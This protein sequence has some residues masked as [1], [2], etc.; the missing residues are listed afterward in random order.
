MEDRLKKVIVLLEKSLGTGD[1]IL[2][3]GFGFI[4][5]VITLVAGEPYSHVALVVKENGKAMV[6]DVD[7]GRKRALDFSPLGKFYLES[8]SL[9]VISLSRFLNKK[10]KNCIVKQVERLFNEN[11]SYDYTF[12]S[13]ENRLYCAEFVKDVFKDCHLLEKLKKAGKNYPELD[14][15]LNRIQ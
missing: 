9:E 6:Y 4:S 14:K 5:K 13:G 12:T 3:R 7:T 8:K 10:E 15:I 1:V 11:P 2:R